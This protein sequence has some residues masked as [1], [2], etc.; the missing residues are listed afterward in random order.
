MVLFYLSLPGRQLYNA[1]LLRTCH[2]CRPMQCS[3]LDESFSRRLARRLSIARR[4]PVLIYLLPGGRGPGYP[5]NSDGE[6]Q[7]YDTHG[8]G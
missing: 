1:L 5:I 2:A 3:T 8:S 6:T 4:G 7:A